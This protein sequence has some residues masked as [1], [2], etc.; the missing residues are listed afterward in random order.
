V[1]ELEIA[2]PTGASRLMM[3][4]TYITLSELSKHNE[5]YLT[6]FFLVYQFLVFSFLVLFLFNRKIIFY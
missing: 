5:K 6:F 1:L 4:A 2:E 3:K